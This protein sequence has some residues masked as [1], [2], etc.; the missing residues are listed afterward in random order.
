MRGRLRNAL[1]TGAVAVSL[2]AAGAA[3]QN[4]R[5]QKIVR[6]K[7]CGDP[8][9]NCPGGPNFQPYDLPFH[10]PKNAVIWESEPFYAVIIKSMK[11][12]ENCEAFVPEEER[13]EAQKLF[14]RNKVF[15]DRCP[16]P[17][18]LYYSN[19]NTDFRLMAVYAGKTRAEADKV[20]SAVRASGKF[21]TANLRRMTTGFNGT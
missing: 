4:R 21:P 10:I 15:T 2:L 1:L 13:L 3:A 12:G 19:T 14:P 8:T 18:T 17:G 16:E 11:A 7:V 5:G 6:G 20:L 9:M